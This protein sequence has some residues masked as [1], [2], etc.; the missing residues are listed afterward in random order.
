MLLRHTIIIIINAMINAVVVIRHEHYVSFMCILYVNFAVVY[1]AC[2]VH[3]YSQ[4][5]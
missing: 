2:L 5:L 3:S 1:N 4:R